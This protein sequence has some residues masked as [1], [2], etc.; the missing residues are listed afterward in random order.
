M[1]MLTIYG[2]QTPLRS[3]AEMHAL[4]TI[5]GMQSVCLPLGKLASHEEFPDQVAQV[6]APFLACNPERG[7]RA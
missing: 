6:V 2:D 5:E 4:A 1:P 7:T 3:H